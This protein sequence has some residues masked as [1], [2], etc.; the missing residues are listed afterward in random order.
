MQSLSLRPS[1]GS[2]FRSLVGPGAPE[3]PSTPECVIPWG[4]CFR[5][6]SEKD[7]VLV[8]SRSRVA[9]VPDQECGYDAA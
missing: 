1:K 8:I 9:G 5:E 7:K 6:G 3:V 2:C 4:T